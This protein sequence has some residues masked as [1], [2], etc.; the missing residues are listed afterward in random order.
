MDL[1][2]V[3]VRKLSY[4]FTPLGT[5]DA[6]ACWS[7]PVWGL[8]G[9]WES[10]PRVLMLWFRGLRLLRPHHGRHCPQWS[11]IFSDTL[12]FVVVRAWQQ[13]GVLDLPA[14]TGGSGGRWWW[15]AWGLELNKGDNPRVPLAPWRRSVWCMSSGIWPECR[16]SEGSTDE[17]PSAPYAWRLLDPMGFGHAHPSLFPDC[18]VLEG[19][20]RSSAICCH[21]GTCF[22]PWWS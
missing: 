4:P 8:F 18:L 2:T 20:A 16:V 3:S 5:S 7:P 19:V 11:L 21:Q 9:C 17:L 6:R 15:A 13:G 12:P 1:E 10:K 22:G 14:F